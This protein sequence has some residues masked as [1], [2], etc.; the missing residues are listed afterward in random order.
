MLKKEYSKNQKTPLCKVTF[1]LPEAIR[2]ENAYLVGDFNK[3]NYN[4]TPMNPLTNGH[5]AVTL[6]L[7]KGREYQFRYLVNSNEWHNDWQAD[8]YVA[9]PFNGDNSVAVI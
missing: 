8:K 6:D 9:N 4:D 2:A 3:W 7:E 1:T 5:F